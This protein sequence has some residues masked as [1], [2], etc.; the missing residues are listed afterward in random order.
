MADFRSQRSPSPDGQGYAK[1]RLEQAYSTYLKAVAPVTVPM[2]NVLK[3]VLWPFARGLT[4]DLVGFWVSWHMLGG[5]DGLRTH[6]GMSRSAVYR[7]I[8]IFRQVV[9]EHPDVYRFPGIELDVE[10]FMRQRAESP[11]GDDDEPD[12]A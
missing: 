5:F 8:A 6:L 11:V 7:R 4:F 10:G 12:E 1:G 3:P 2:S 9:G